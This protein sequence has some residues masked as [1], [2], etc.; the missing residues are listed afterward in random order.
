MSD[1]SSEENEK[2]AIGYCFLK[3]QDLMDV[4]TDLSELDFTQEYCKILYSLIK[5]LFLEKNEC[6]LVL[7]IEKINSIK[8]KEIE[9]KR[10]IRLILME[11][12]S[13]AGCGGYLDSIIDVLKEKTK[14][15]TFKELIS[16]INF[17][18]TCGEFCLKEEIDIIKDT[19]EKIEHGRTSEKS[20]SLNEGV[21]EYKK[22]LEKIY[23]GEGTN[24]LSFGFRDLDCFVSMRPGNLVLL[25]ARPSVGKTTMAVNILRHVCEDKKL[26]AAFF[27]IEMT[28]HEMVEKTALCTAELEAFHVEQEGFKDKA[29]AALDKVIEKNIPAYFLNLKSPTMKQIAQSASR[30][31]EAFGIKL[32]VIDYLQ[33]IKA[34]NTKDPKYVQI[35]DISMSL[36]SLAKEL[37]IPVLCLSQLSRE[38]DKRPDPTPHLGDLRDSGSLEADADIVIFMSRKDLRDQFDRP[39]QVQISVA[40]NRLGETRT[41]SL[42]NEYAK[43]RIEDIK[44]PC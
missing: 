41:L 13:A 28:E 10:Q 25:A 34:E 35:T 18:V 32:L 14:A 22:K 23:K 40:K 3:H 24:S 39:G 7:M 11:T 38:V 42:K 29:F 1:F 36:K 12:I 27:C 33:L 26:P 30:M 17:K 5:E 21:K 31:K 37:D 19:I 15:R 43:C 20:I 6:D 4:M 9:E 2:L 16:G 8:D 44:F